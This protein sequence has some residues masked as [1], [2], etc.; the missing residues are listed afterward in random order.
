MFATMSAP[1]IL[2][3]AERNGG[4]RCGNGIRGRRFGRRLCAE[5]FD[6]FPQPV[7]FRQQ[8]GNIFP[9]GG[10]KLAMSDARKFDIPAAVA[11]PCAGYADHAVVR[12]FDKSV[13]PVNPGTVHTAAKAC[14]N[15]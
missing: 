9:S 10:Q 12:G 14:A 5:P 7:H 15:G 1:E 4:F 13:S 3:H 11:V 8:P 6:L 2:P